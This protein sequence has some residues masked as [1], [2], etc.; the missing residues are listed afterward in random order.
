MLLCFSSSLL[1]LFSSQ[2]NKSAL[3]LNTDAAVRQGALAVGLGATIRDDNGRV[4]AIAKPIVG[5][6]TATAGELLALR[7]GLLL[8]KNYNLNVLIAE[9]DAFSVA[10]VLNSMDPL[11]GDASFIVNDVKALW[12]CAE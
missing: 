2:G 8:A 7:E 4:V 5:I 1:L 12:M 10:S 9:V 11:L 6:F 3:K